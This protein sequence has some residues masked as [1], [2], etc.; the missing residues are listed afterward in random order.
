[1]GSVLETV[2]KASIEVLFILSMCL[3]FGFSA[4]IGG[5]MLAGGVH[6]VI[7][8]AK[9]LPQTAARLFRR[10]GARFTAQSR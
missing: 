1:M 3:V 4:L 6:A 8:G 7:Q 9:Q 10:L 5:L 2:T